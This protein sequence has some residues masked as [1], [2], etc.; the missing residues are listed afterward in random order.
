MADRSRNL[1]SVQKARR[2][3][4]VKAV[5]F[6]KNRITTVLSAVF[7]VFSLIGWWFC[8]APGSVVII[9]PVCAGFFLLY[10]AVFICILWIFDSMKTE[11]ASP[12]KERRASVFLFEGNVFVKFLIISG[13]VYGLWWIVFFPGTL[14]P[15]MTHHLYQGLGIQ[16]LNKMVPVFLTKLVGIIMTVSKVYFLNDNVG[17]MIYVAGLLLLQCFTV[18]YM[19]LIFK[20]LET[21]FLVR[22]LA[23]VYVYVIP[24]LPAWGVNFGKDAPYY[25]F[26]LLFMCS[27]IDIMISKKAGIIR[28]LCFAT[29]ILGCALSRNNGFAM[30]VTALILYIFLVRKHLKIYIPV[31]LVCVLI[32]FGSDKFFASHYNVGDTPLR[33]NLSVPIQTYVSYLREFGD[34][35]TE[36]D[37]SNIQMLFSASPAELAESYDPVVADPVKNRFIDPVSDEQM[38]VFWSLWK[39]GFK[40]HPGVFIKGLLRHSYGYF[41]PG[42]GCYRDEI[43]IYTL[44]FHTEYYTFEF[45]KSDSA[46]RNAFIA[47]SEGIY[48]FPLTNMLYRPGFQMLVMMSLAV[49]ILRSKAKRNILVMIPSLMMVF[50]VLS[51][52]SAYFRYMLPVFAALPITLA[53]AVYSMGVVRI[54]NSENN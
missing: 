41:Y 54:K 21:P 37:I 3:E 20:K 48:K 30:I 14:H 45:A 8:S 26:I 9:L 32:I 15:D 35:L 44:N 13:V 49:C 50:V 18:S 4:E 24:V 17:V 51:P 38:D 1:G 5:G 33:E 46:L 43:S 39:K 10:K 27:L 28:F 11:C 16:P 42:A 36:E 53:W 31:C 2:R 52:V 19:F 22:W 7:A 25:N 34:E 40:A 6:L 29:S 47:F 12:G 23:L